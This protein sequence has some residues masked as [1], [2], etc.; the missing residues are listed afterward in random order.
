M[1]RL[2]LLV[3]GM[4]AAWAALIGAAMLIGNAQPEPNQLQALGFDFCEGKPCWQ[5]ITPGVT[6]W[7][8]VRAIMIP[9]GGVESRSLGYTNI[10]SGQV[11]SIGNTVYALKLSNQ[12]VITSIDYVPSPNITFTS[13]QQSRVIDALDLFGTPC[14]VKGGS[15]PG[16]IWLLYPHVVVQVNAAQYRIDPTS[17][18]D[19]VEVFD[20]SQQLNQTLPGD[21]CV[22]NHEFN[23]LIYSWKGLASM[24]FYSTQSFKAGQ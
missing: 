12:E 18:I 1:I 23:F 10:K 22:S 3:G 14:G 24:D 19:Y 11:D 6:D 16:Q 17:P 8:V 20:P 21:L 4:L 7:A 13:S 15:K 2:Y 5:G 9:R